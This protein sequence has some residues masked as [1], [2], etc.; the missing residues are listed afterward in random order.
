MESLRQFAEKLAWRDLRGESPSEKR[1]F[2]AA[3]KSGAPP[4]NESFSTL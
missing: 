3:L 2:I 1:G 4:E